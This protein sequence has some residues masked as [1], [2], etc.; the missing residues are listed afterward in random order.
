MFSI[1][2][3]TLVLIMLI[4]GILAMIRGF[5]R[6][7][8]SIA[9]WAASVLSV[10]ILLKYFPETSS[11]L[12]KFIGHKVA[13]QAILS[14]FIATIVLVIVHLITILISDRI[15]SSSMGALDHTLGFVF[16]LGRGLVAVVVLYLLFAN[17]V[18]KQTHDSWVLNSGSLPLVQGTGE[19]II[20]LLPE[21]L[22]Q[23]ITDKIKKSN[24]ND[25]SSI[26]ENQSRRKNTKVDVNRGYQGNERRGLDQLVESTGSTVQN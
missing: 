20:S 6:E 8:L 17:L 18:T 24:E 14:L 1:L 10:W 7:F 26:E 3:V 13:A 4:S 21:D 23:D 11:I 15:L 2:D 19:M 9:S 12:E 5:T 16:G 25:Q 22:A